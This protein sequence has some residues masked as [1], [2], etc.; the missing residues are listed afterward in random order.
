MPDIIF[1][2]SKGVYRFEKSRRIVPQKRIDDLVSKVAD[3]TS[4]RLGKLA[5]A[6]AKGDISLPAWVLESTDEI[7]AGHR[8]VSMIAS[9]G[10]SR[11]GPREWGSAG[12]RM[13]SELMYFT[14]FSNEVDTLELGAAFEARAASYGQAVY[15][16]HA[17][18]LAMRHEKDGTASTES[19]I[20]DDGAAHCE[21]CLEADAAGEVPLGTLTP[22]GARDCGSRCRCR[23]VYS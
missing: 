15:S 19:N 18:G 17:Q 11:M 23:I 5:S 21:G 12:A 22:I 7:K 9:G 10:K 14:A 2:T 20:L 8:A 6:Y 16:T 4:I 3:R 1:D 13:R